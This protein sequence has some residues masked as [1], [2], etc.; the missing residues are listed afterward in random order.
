[1]WVSES[2]ILLNIKCQSLQVQPQLFYLTAEG[3][4]FVKHTSKKLNE[5]VVNNDF[6]FNLIKKRKTLKNHFSICISKTNTWTNVD[7]QMNLQLKETP[8]DPNELLHLADRQETLPQQASC[9]LKQWIGLN[10]SFQMVFQ[11]SV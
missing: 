5:T 8:A 7:M 4:D 11:R 3:S 2:R 1:M 10:N 6:I 9:Q